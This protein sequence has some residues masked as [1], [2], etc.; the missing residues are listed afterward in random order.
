MYHTILVPL[1]GSPRA[2]RILPHVEAVAQKFGAQLVLVQVVEPFRLGVYDETWVT[3]VEEIERLTQEARTYL[4]GLQDRLRTKHIQAKTVVEYGP[5]VST[6]LTVAKRENAD[7]IALASHGRTGLGRVFY[8]SVAAGLLNQ[9][10][11][12]LLLIR[13][14]D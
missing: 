10:D 11:H 1:D 14:Q 4:S 6:L 13:A 8:G 9:S 12:P 3:Y 2:E 7:L 5:V